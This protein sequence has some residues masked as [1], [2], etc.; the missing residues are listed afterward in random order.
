MKIVRLKKNKTKTSKFLLSLRN[1]KYVRINSL[2]KKI[3]KLKDHQ[4]WLDTFLKKK[5]NKIFIIKMNKVEIGY[6]RLFK[7]NNFYEA[8]WAI[9]NKFKGKKIISKCLRKTTDENKKKYK[10]IVNRKNIASIKAA[11]NAGFTI[12]RRVKSL[13][14]MYK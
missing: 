13:I 5:N 4:F 2:N 10:A 14:Y 12:K 9:L 7:N 8:S 1:K 11:E 3:I 6:V